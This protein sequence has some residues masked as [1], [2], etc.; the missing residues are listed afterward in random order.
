MKMVITKII[1]R[2]NQKHYRIVKFSSD[3]HQDIIRTEE[4]DKRRRGVRGGRGE[5][6][7]E[8][9]SLREGKQEKQRSRGAEKQIAEADD[10]GRWEGIETE[11]GGVGAERAG[12]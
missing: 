11:D 12:N 10:D 2:A 9:R 1:C 5:G 4:L 6:E 7:V 3:F 8:V